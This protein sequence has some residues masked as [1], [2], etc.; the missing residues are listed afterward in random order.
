[1]ILILTVSSFPLVYA[2][3]E[4]PKIIVN[5]AISGTDFPRE[6]LGFE[7]QQIP[8]LLMLCGVFLALVVAING[9]KWLL[10][11]SI[12]MCGERMLRR[13]RFLLFEHVMRFRMARFRTTRPGEVIQSMVGEIE[14]LGGF[15]GEVI[16]TPAFQ[17][18]LLVVYVTFIFVQDVWLGLAAVSLYPIQAFLIPKLQA[19]VIRLNKARAGNTRQLADAIS[20]SV[21]N[22][23]D[24][25][26]NDT[27]RWHMA[28]ISQRL[29]TNT[30]IRMDL[31]RRKF[32]IKFINNFMNQLTP[33][34]FYSVGGYLV[35]VGDLDFGSLV[36]VLAAYKDLAGPWKAVLTYV[37]R[38]ADFN[39]RYEFVVDS[40][41]GD[42]IYQPE[43][44]FS[45]QT[46]A[47]RGDL[48]LEGIEGGPGTGGLVAARV[49]ISGGQSVAVKGGETGAREALL[50]IMAGLLD[51][52]SGRATVGERVLGD[53]TMPELGTTVAYVGADPGIIS[54]S[55][56]DNLIYGLLRCAPDLA[57]QSTAEAVVLLREARRTGNITADPGG[58]WIDYAAAGA[59]DAAALDERLLA[60]VDHVG[61]ADDLVTSALDSRIDPADAELWTG[62]ILAARAELTAGDDQNLADIVEPWVPG[63]FNSNGALIANILFG[64]PQQPIDDDRDY[65]QIPWVV[66]VLERSGARAELEAIGHNI[67]QE[68]TDLVDAVDE[69]SSVLDSFAAYPKATIQGAAEIIRAGL[70]KPIDQ[71]P[72]EHRDTLLILAMGFIQTRD[73]LD[74]L[75]D[76]GIER[77]LACQA[78]G[79][80]MLAGR[81]DFV[82]FDEERFSPGRSVAE[83]ILNG[84]R[85]F[86][87]RS[88]WKQLSERI[89]AAIRSAGL[90]EDLIRL[91]LGAPA[92]SGGANLS[93]NA[94]RRVALVRAL[95][96]RPRFLIMDGI[97]GGT[98]PADA[99]LRAAIRDE[100]PETS[101]V[102]AAADAYAG[103]ADM[104]IEIDAAGSARATEVTEP[105][106]EPEPESGHTTESVEDEADRRTP[107]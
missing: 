80:E 46:D 78:K 61:L 4:I 105:D 23:A 16:A 87:R 96:K 67:A 104:E 11:V 25:H 102:F 58:D 83:N 8:Y 81:D 24:I 19:K 38:W 66:D 3:L 30:L 100:L 76:A 15:I 69:N 57:E 60:L 89:E 77:L 43:R 86:D 52:A 34:F 56:R 7:F 28:Q 9:I 47:L 26:T 51:P 53:V 37:Q 70:G 18:G 17:G 98:D 82:S 71:L 20:E 44:I 35:I 31:F 2:S 40:F 6:I 73:R 64:L 55:I 27:A 1:M 103:R 75:D 29:H 48:R 45:K 42:D 74:A 54:R 85:R 21:S 59:E 97:A 13:L 5:D 39:S 63:Q 101:I 72:Q 41:L 79:R 65:L 95:L 12:G 93:G 94:R 106:P 92:G 36:A 88:A 32:T 107:P 68:F 84:K 90:R 10:N 99:T 50:R 33:F 91:G 14:P 62:P 49:Q 22:V